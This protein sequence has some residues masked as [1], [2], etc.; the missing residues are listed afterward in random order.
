MLHGRAAESGRLQSLFAAAAGGRGGALVVR[1]EPGVG[2]TALLAD[3]TRRRAGV[4]LLWTQGVESESPLAFAA[5]HRLLHPVLGL[6]D[7]LPPAQAAALRVAL[8]TDVGP[9]ADRL[10]VF[11]ATL[12]LLAEAADEG[13]VVAVVDDAHWLD[14]ASAEALLFAGRRLGSDRV[15]MVFGARDGDVLRFDAPGVDDITLRGLDAAAAGDLLA[16]RIGRSVPAEVRDALLAHTGGNPLALVEFPSV[17]SE[18]QLTGVTGLPARLPLTTGVERTFLDRCRRLGADGQTFLLGAAADDSGRRA[19]VRAAAAG[20]GLDE[21]ALAAAEQSGLVRLTGA[22]LRFRHPLVRSAVYGAAPMAERHRV[23]AA[24]AAVLAAAG[25]ADRR[26]WHLALATEG[27]D[28]EV[29]RELDAVA[30][31]SGARGGHA[32]ASAAWERAAALTART[33]PRAHRLQ[34]G[35]MSAWVAGHPGRARTLAE[36]ARRYA[37]DPI[38]AADVDRLR[39][40]LEWSVGSA[41]TGHRIVMVAAREVAPYDPVRALEMAML[42]TAL[43]TYGADSGVAG[44]DTAGF[45]PPLPADAAPRLRCLDALLSGQQHLIGGRTAAA[46]VALRRSFEL[47]QDAGE[48]LDLLVNTALAAC[49]L[50]D[51]DVAMRDFSRLLEIA[52]TGGS[53]SLILVAL[54]RLP[55]AQ[56]ARGEWDAANAATEEALTLAV[57]TGRPALTALP[58]AWRALLAAF[59][60]APG[61]PDALAELAELLAGHQLGV[62]AAVVSDVAEWARGIAA[63]ADND[64]DAAFRHFCRISLPA[65]QRLAALDLVEA[66]ARAGHPDAVTDRAA[67][68]ERLSDGM[69]AAWA[70][71]VAAHA[72]ALVS[73]G[74]VAVS[75]FDRALALHRRGP[76]P[77]DQARTQ[78]A[79]GEFLRRAGRRVDARPL[80]RASLEGFEGLGAAAWADRASSELRASGETARQREPSTVGQLTPQEL[81]IARLVGQGLSNR[82]VAGRLF[83]SPRTVEYHLSH[84]YQ[85]LGVRSRGGLVGIP[86]G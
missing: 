68:L 23:H 26:A 41:L 53:V 81:Q 37:A 8:G 38:L 39:A 19:A 24:L 85:K 77:F 50:G 22:E 66:A 14:P 21:Q 36:E 62:G 42:G 3:A 40:R 69:D 43:A 33:E 15:A 30:R 51:F 57:A 29:A 4:R 54:S 55:I 27:P 20:L 6:L 28:E 58:L 10:V 9:A 61:G 60:G 45:L 17:L 76:R 73:G 25:E 7:R 44:I 2:K 13:P 47:V 59:R 70:G 48:D 78:L 71:A 12:S 86:L 35:A 80:L 5:L 82:D 83:V 74:A 84:A 64:P 56:V 32:A 18:D 65:V 63:A 46:A 34:A 31:R 72:R 52:R 1:G 67:E 49:H 75:H 79:F 16:D 11:V